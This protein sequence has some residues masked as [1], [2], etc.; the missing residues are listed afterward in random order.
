MSQNRKIYSLNQKKTIMKTT[1]KLLLGLFFT[2]LVG[3]S[4][5]AQNDDDWHLFNPATLGVTNPVNNISDHIVT[6]GSVGIG[7]IDEDGTFA[8]VDAIL[9][10]VSDTLIYDSLYATTNPAFTRFG[11]GPILQDPSMVVVNASGVVNSS[12]RIAEFRSSRR[13]Q[14]DASINI[15]GSRD[16]STTANIATLE[17]SNYDQNDNGEFV[18][19]TVSAGMPINTGDLG[20]L[21]FSTADGTGVQSRFYMDHRGNVG[22]GDAT[23]F[24]SAALPTRNLDVQGNARIRELPNDNYEEQDALNVVVDPDGN[25]HVQS[26]SSGATILNC[27][28]KDYIPKVNGSGGLDCSIIQDNGTQ[29]GINAAPP[30]VYGGINNPT[31]HIGGTITSTGASFFN[32]DSRFKRNINR[33]D[34]A[35]SKI[36]D[37]EGFT[38]EFRTDEFEDRNFFQGRTYGLIAQNVEEV[39]PELVIELDGYKSVNYDGLIPVLLEGIKEQQEQIEQLK[40]ELEVLKGAKVGGQLSIP[41]NDHLNLSIDKEAFQGYPNPT[42]GNFVVSYQLPEHYG[43]ASVIITDLQGSLLKE[44]AVRSQQGELEFNCADLSSGIYLYTLVVNNEPV[45]SRKMVVK[46]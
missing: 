10:V 4:G 13:A 24:S 29:V 14:Q 23:T 31:L 9:H 25:L 40:E 2:G 6:N 12:S 39:L 44:S 46:K 19:A 5:N 7:T 33:V 26:L 41:A 34:G 43:T 32:S 22:L 37:L 36:A 42:G 8:R 27:T 21:R 20:F 1:K 17:L 28:S 30:T 38:Y 45:L 3:Y 15:R 16:G 35:L 11:V 18:L